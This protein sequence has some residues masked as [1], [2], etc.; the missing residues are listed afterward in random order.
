MGRIRADVGVYWQR[1]RGKNKPFGLDPG[2]YDRTI[3]VCR[4]N[5]NTAIGELVT[6]CQ[7]RSSWQFYIYVKLIINM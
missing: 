7:W 3:V 5:G 1:T 4:L 6:H 2:H